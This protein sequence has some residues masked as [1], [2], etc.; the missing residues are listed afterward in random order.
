M[1]QLIMSVLVA[2][3]LTGAAAAAMRSRAPSSHT[4]GAVSKAAPD[5][6]RSSK[7]LTEAYD[8]MPL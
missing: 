7:P 5:S 8:D 4:V 3:V 1:N 6:C 2:V